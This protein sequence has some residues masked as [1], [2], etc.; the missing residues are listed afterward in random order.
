MYCRHTRRLKLTELLYWATD[1][2]K[3]TTFS[4]PLLKLSTYKG[5]EPFFES[6]R[7]VTLEIQSFSAHVACRSIFA[8]D[9]QSISLAIGK[10]GDES[11]TSRMVDA[12]F[13]LIASHS[14]K[15]E[16]LKLEYGDFT[17]TDAFR[18]S[19][20]KRLANLVG[21]LDRTAPKL[22]RIDFSPL[23]SGNVIV[24]AL[25]TMK[26]LQDIALGWGQSDTLHKYSLPQDSFGSLRAIKLNSEWCPQLSPLFLL[27]NI[28]STAMERISV[29]ASLDVAEVV[30]TNRLVASQWP[31]TLRQYHLGWFPFGTDTVNPT[32]IIPSH[33]SVLS[34]LLDEILQCHQLR[35]L[36]LPIEYPWELTDEHI[37]ALVRAL[38]EL[39]SLE[40][41]S[42]NRS[43]VAEYPPR[44]T[45]KGLTSIAVGLS[46]LES[47]TM[48][49]NVTDP[50]LDE[51]ALEA[52]ANPR[53][54]KFS[55]YNVGRGRPEVVRDRIRKLFPSLNQV[56]VEELRGIS[57][58]VSGTARNDEDVDNAW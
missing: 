56:H 22:K 4:R 8:Y 13:D 5:T 43:T 23:Q 36:S 58:G 2:Y 45:V 34:S 21:R 15:L 37:T 38:P 49:I 19:W 3:P 51:T 20:E 29:E 53:I 40:L 57:G 17:A 33:P 6:L 10:P 9:L 48:D 24:P 42:K 28:S 50:S 26:G 25:A 31:K 11:S 30:R 14:V 12:L 47:L 7:H 1:D 44:V 41:G 18:A 52:A 32:G 46:Y 39:R 55:T 54:R 16:S 27:S 35:I